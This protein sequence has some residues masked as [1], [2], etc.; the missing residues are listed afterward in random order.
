MESTYVEE[1]TDEG[2]EWQE[3][4]EPTFESC[5]LNTDASLRMS[6]DVD[7]ME[8][9]GEVVNQEQPVNIMGHEQ[10]DSVSLHYVKFRGFYWP[11]RKG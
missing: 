11:E 9:P 8:A 5:T 2:E 1:G 7:M 3:I 4:V 6:V 10:D